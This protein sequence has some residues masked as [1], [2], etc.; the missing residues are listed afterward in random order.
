LL[1]CKVRVGS[2]GAEAQPASNRETKAMAG[3]NKGRIWVIL[4]IKVRFNRQRFDFTAPP[5]P[6]T[7]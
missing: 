6:F 7:F 3:T 4:K 5:L 2:F 1:V